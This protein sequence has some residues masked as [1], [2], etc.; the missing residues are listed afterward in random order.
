MKNILCISLLYCLISSGYAQTITFT[1]KSDRLTEAKGHSIPVFGD[2]PVDNKNQITDEKSDAINSHDDN[3]SWIQMVALSSKGKP[4]HVLIYQSQGGDYE[5]PLTQQGWKEKTEISYWIMDDAEYG[6]LKATVNKKEGADT[7]I[8]TYID[9]KSYSITAYSETELQNKIGATLNGN[10]GTE[11]GAYCMILNS[12]NDVI[13]FLLPQTCIST[14]NL[15]HG[16]YE[17]K[18]DEF[19]KLLID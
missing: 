1:K 7:H 5:Y 8:T 10:L 15:K 16:Y 13:R 9:Q 2:P 18:T 17:V 12:Q 4:Y 11:T 19:K 3:F 14:D 6:L